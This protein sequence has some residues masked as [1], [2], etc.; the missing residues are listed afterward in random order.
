MNVIIISEESSNGDPRVLE[1]M[2]VFGEKKFNIRGRKCQFVR[3][4]KIKIP[5]KAVF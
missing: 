4:Q 1:G 5:I 2:N 3:L